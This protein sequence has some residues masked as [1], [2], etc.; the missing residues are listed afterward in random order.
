MALRRGRKLIRVTSDAAP[1]D[2]LT[3]AG[4]IKTVVDSERPARVF[5]DVGPAGRGERRYPA[6]L[7]EP[8]ASRL[9]LVN[10]G[11]A[12]D[13]AGDGA[14]GRLAPVGAEEPARGD[15]GEVEGLAGAGRRR[16]HPRQRRASS[17]RSARRGSA[18]T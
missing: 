12:S 13:G 15:V 6:E 8:Y 18:T 4:R 1:V 2:A 14:G 17:G 5:M 16:G 7:G 11:S 9:V 10:F 3:A